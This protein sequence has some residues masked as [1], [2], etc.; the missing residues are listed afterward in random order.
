MKHI[1]LLSLCACLGACNVKDDTPCPPDPSPELMEVIIHEYTD[2]WIN[3]IDKIVATLP[4]G[5]QSRLI[6]DPLSG[7]NLPDAAVWP[8]IGADGATLLFANP[9]GLFNY[10]I[11]RGRVTALIRNQS[12][13]FDMYYLYS[14]PD[15]SSDM[16]EING[17]SIG[18]IFSVRP[19]DGFVNP[20]HD[21]R[22]GVRSR[23]TGDGHFVFV[24]L[25]DE[26]DGPLLETNQLVSID[27]AGRNLKLIHQ[28]EFM[29]E[30]LPISLA[31]MPLPGSREVI[32]L[33]QSTDEEEYRF[34]RTDI[35]GSYRITMDV[36]PASEGEITY[37]SVGP[38]GDKIAYFVQK[39][40]ADIM[41]PQP[42]V[43]L[44]V[45]NYSGNRLTGVTSIPMP[46]EMTLSD[47]T[48]G[49]LRRPYLGKIRRDLWDA[50]PEL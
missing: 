44:I 14:Q 48:F 9:F 4:D 36:V 28:F 27:R 40:P 33:V 11:E 26:W 19:S 22:S 20:I 18:M 3:S 47:F 39:Q 34:V 10:S 42:P 35:E 2:L 1:L 46:P 41:D 23:Q 49:M 32:Y 13:M 45:R 25:I 38:N 29:T 16:R 7:G 31:T 43:E 17:S 15:F 6:L 21:L 8:S 30:G 5:S 50:L 24:R 37:F 12:D